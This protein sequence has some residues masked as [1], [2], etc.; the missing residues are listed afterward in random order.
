MTAGPPPSASDPHVAALLG[1]CTFPAVGTEV[2]CGV[3][4]G[5]DSTALL[6][7]AVAHG[8]VVTAVHVDHGLRPGGTDEAAAVGALGLSYAL[9]LGSTDSRP[10]HLALAVLMGGVS[11]YLVTRPRPSRT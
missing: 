6:A 10:L 4:G 11:L 5:A 1:R 2:T 8:L 9:I 7:L 3:S